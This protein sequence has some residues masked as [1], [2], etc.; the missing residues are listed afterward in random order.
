MRREVQK[1]CGRFE[2]EQEVMKKILTMTGD[3]FTLL[4]F[5][6]G[7]TGIVAIA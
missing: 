6:T 3:I 7:V 5:L 4:I 2:E 1:A